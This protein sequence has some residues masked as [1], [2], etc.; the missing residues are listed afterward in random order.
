MIGSAASPVRPP[1][2]SLSRLIAE[3]K[4]RARRR[5]LL[6]LGAVVVLA[7]AAVGTT[8]GLRTSGNSLGLCATPPSGWKQR[9]A[10][11]FSSVP[12]IVL[13]NFRFGRPNYFY[14]I[15]DFNLSWPRDGVIIAVQSSPRTAH[16]EPGALTVA[17]SDFRAAEGAKLPVAALSVLSH[18][19]ALI[20]WVEVGSV[21]PAT[22]AAANQALAGVRVCST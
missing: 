22:I 16:A 21:S 17:A 20:A 6:A 2:F 4:E 1:R 9:P 5:R 12:T 13:T 15:N 19:R 7:A 8:Y 18:G 11:V 3:A 10:T 14:G